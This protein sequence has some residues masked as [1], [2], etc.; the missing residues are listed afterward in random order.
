MQCSL[1]NSTHT[2]LL[3]KTKKRTYYQCNH[4]STICLHPDF[5]L[6]LTFEK[7]RYDKHSDNIEDKGYQ[8]FVSPLINSIT[9]NYKTTSLGLD[10][11]CGK[12][13]IVQQLL[14][15]KGFSISGYDPIYFPN[16]DSLKFTYDF[17][18]CCEV[19]EHFYTPLFE[20]KK[21]NQL[22]LPKGKLFLKTY[23]YNSSID[24]GSWWYK[25]DPTH[26]VFYT[27]KSLEFIKENCSFSDLHIHN[28]HIIL[29]K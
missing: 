4:C 17:I 25:N 26:V 11:G 15:R 23:L 21:L 5:Y 18:T 2:L 9:T 20:F 10:Y 3:F 12:T 19:A 22:L 16:I 29:S 13:A 8:N 14:Q 6:N 1:C 7:E 24:F 27:K 28:D